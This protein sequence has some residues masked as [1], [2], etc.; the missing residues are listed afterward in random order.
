MMNNKM[1]EA[2][3]NAGI[4]KEETKVYSVT[5]SNNQCIFDGREDLE[6]LEEVIRF[7]VGRGNKYK[8]YVSA[9]KDTVIA[10]YYDRKG[11]FTIDHDGWGDVRYYNQEQFKY[12]LDKNL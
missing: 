9:G 7:I 11:L 4:A 2:I 5:L 6:T 3:K 12:Y 8:V 10:T 1:M